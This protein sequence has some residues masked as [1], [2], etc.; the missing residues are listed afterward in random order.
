ML[1]AVH[2]FQWRDARGDPLRELKNSVNSQSETTFRY[3]EG[4]RLLD[5]V[6]HE[7]KTTSRVVYEY[8]D[9]PHGNWSAMKETRDGAT[10]TVASRSIQYWT[11]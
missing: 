4:G 1:P 5:S 10:L 8:L 3:G 6:A 11:E 9:D 2:N 7:G